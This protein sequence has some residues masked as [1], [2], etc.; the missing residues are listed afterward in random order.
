MRQ[1]AGRGA[2]H[3]LQHL[4]EYNPRKRFGI[5]AAFLLHSVPNLIDE[6][7]DMYTRLVGR[8]FNK[9]DKRRWETFQNNGRRINRKLHDF[10]VLGRGLIEAKDKKLDLQEA[11]ESV[12]GWEE[13]AI[14]VGETENLAAPLDFSN[15]N[16]LSSQYSQAR[17]YAPRFLSALEFQAIPRR[18][19]LLK[20]VA[21][22]RTLN[23]NE[24]S[25]VPQNAP[26]EF[27]PRRWRPYVFDDDKIDRAYSEL[28]VLN[29]LSSALRSGDVWVPGSRR[30]L[31]LDD[32]LLSQEA[33]RSLPPRQ[34]MTTCRQYFDERRSQLHDSLQRVSRLLAEGQLPDVSLEDGV[35]SISPLKADVPAEVDLWSDRLYDLLPRIHLTDLLMEVDSWTGISQ[36]FT[37]LYT[38][39]PAAD[40]TLVF[41]V[42]LSDATNIGLTKIA[43]ATPGRYMPV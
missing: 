29:E 17:Q 28:C 37:H 40:R 43:D 9:A 35:L 11:I 15:L 10:I 12:I 39:Q 41:T 31:P 1:L 23:Q 7:I 38:Q 3:T 2:R 25:G 33:W 30:Y 8:W 34:P 13:L 20:A 16:E 22:L 42:I 21:T 18:Q 27:V 36:Y 26:R 14:S 32:Y 24:Q 19:S 6:L 5:V 4:R